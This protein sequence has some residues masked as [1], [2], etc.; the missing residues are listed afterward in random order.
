M[1]QG[2]T[3]GDLTWPSASADYPRRRHV[4]RIVTAPA[5]GTHIVGGEYRE[6]DQ[7]QRTVSWSGRA[8][9][10][11]RRLTACA[12]PGRDRRLTTPDADRGIAASH[13]QAVD[14][15]CSMVFESNPCSGC[16]DSWS[17]NAVRLLAKS[18][19]RCTKTGRVRPHVACDA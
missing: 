4:K 16:E 3:A 1:R 2:R 12:R 9:A 19:M 15:A 5:G 7:D 13:A 6:I 14:P 10:L 18:L 8:A 11:S 17:I